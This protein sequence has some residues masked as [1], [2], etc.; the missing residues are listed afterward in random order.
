ML[1]KTKIEEVIEITD[2]NTGEK[3]FL[4][5]KDGEWINVNEKEY[6]IFLEGEKN[7]RIQ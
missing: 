3:K 5:L 1:L 4:L 2:H 6:N 7:D